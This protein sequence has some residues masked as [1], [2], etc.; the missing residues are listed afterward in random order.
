MAVIW[1]KKIDGSVYQI[2][3]AG[4]TRRLYTNGV[5][6]SE[7][8]PSK[9][10]TGSIWDLLILPAFFYE[11]ESVRRILMLGVG[12]GASILQLHHLLQVENICGV[13]LDPVH[14]ELAH[15]FF[16]IESIP[17]DLHNAEARQWLQEYQGDAF[18]LIIDDLFT[19]KGKEPVRALEADTDW[20]SLLLSHLSETGRL[21][22]NFASAEEFRESAY[23]QNFRISKQFSAAFKLTNVQ[24]DNIVGAFLRLDSGTAQLRANV[25]DNPVLARALQNKQLRYNIRNVSIV[26]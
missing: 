13:E 25:M 6:H 21:V 2:R 1:Q 19:S 5:C 14:L 24:L 20:F 9:V 16:N 12:G 7:F 17:V 22:I 23:F 10:L 3:S 18:D 15:R 26:P 11:P 4:K 8:N